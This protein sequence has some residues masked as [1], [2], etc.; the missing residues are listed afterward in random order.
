MDLKQGDIIW[1]D[2][3]PQSGHEQ[4][5]RRP[6]LIISKTNFYRTTSLAMVCPITNTDNGFPLHIAIPGF[7]KTSGFV[8]CEQ[9]KTLDI[10]SRKAEFIEHLDDEI[11]NLALTMVQE[12]LDHD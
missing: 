3:N 6:A 1:L 7:H 10:Q 2:M 4:A 12:I 11:L 5:G 9:A 8:L